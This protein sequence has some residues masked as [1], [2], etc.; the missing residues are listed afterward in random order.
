MK[1]EKFPHSDPLSP[2]E[3]EGGDYL[4]QLRGCKQ[5]NFNLKLIFVLIRWF[6]KQNSG[7][8]AASNFVRQVMEKS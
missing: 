8:V 2:S 3:Q 5:N 7:V 1:E 4:L 6:Q